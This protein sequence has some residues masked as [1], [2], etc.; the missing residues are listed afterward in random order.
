MDGARLA[1]LL[2]A[3]LRLALA[4][5]CA[6][7]C[8][9]MMDS[10]SMRLDLA[11]RVTSTIWSRPARRRRRATTSTHKTHIDWNQGTCNNKRSDVVALTDLRAS[12]RLTRAPPAAGRR[13]DDGL[14]TGRSGCGVAMRSF[15]IPA[16]PWL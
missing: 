12:P 5:C 15:Y 6:S 4:V 2:S 10:S 13:T 3:L 9:R 7:E 1:G 8:A 16:K 11:A 14:R